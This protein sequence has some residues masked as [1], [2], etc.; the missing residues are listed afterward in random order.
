MHESIFKWVKTKLWPPSVEGLKTVGFTYAGTNTKKIET[1][2]DEAKD[3]VTF[4]VKALGVGTFTSMLIGQML[5]RKAKAATSPV[6]KRSL[7]VARFTWSATAVFAFFYG[8][9]KIEDAMFETGPFAVNLK[10]K[11][12]EFNT[13]YKANAEAV[14]QRKKWR[15]D[16]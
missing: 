13:K 12:D 2:G 16:D 4:M 5:K 15:D 3:K 6:M 11:R 9:S 14:I 10:N 8:L 1:V 7:K